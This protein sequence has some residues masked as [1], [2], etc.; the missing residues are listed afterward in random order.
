MLPQVLELSRIKGC[1]TFA[2]RKLLTVL[3]GQFSCVLSNL[4]IAEATPKHFDTT[5]AF[6]PYNNPYS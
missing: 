4:F 3:C 1:I 2:M 5:L 6:L